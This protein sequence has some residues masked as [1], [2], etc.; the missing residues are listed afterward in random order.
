M[1][2]SS[3]SE[4]IAAKIRNSYVVPEPL[5]KQSA[6]ELVLLHRLRLI[7]SDASHPLLLGDADRSQGPPGLEQGPLVATTSEDASSSAAE[8]QHRVSSLPV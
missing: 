8:D 4:K 3:R 2:E 5:M 1:I 7:R 6:G